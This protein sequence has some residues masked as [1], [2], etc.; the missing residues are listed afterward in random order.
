VGNWRLKLTRLFW[1]Y[2]RFWRGERRVILMESAARI[3]R[4]ILRDGESIRSVSR[5]TGLSRNT[6]RK[7]LRDATPPRYHR[8]L[9]PV[10]RK[11]A[12]YEERLRALFKQDLKRPRRERRTATKLYE[13]LVEEGYSGSYNPV[14]RFVRMLKKDSSQLSQAFI[15]LHFKPGEASS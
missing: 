13:L 4:L 7:Y 11:L 12:D 8:Q 10:R 9:P 1:Y 14:C 6:I 2:P 5:S 15:P 3:R